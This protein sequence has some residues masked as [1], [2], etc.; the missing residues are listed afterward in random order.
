M[1]AEFRAA[2]LAGF[3]ISVHAIGDRA[4]R[5][6]LD[7]FEEL[8]DAGLQPPLPHRIEHVQILDPADWSRLAALGVTASVQP[9]HALDDMDT[10]ELFLGERTA[11]IYAFRSLL[12]SGALLAFGS[13]GPVADVN[14]FVGLHAAVVRQRPANLPAPAWHGEQRLTMAEAVYAYTLG[15]ARAVG[16]DNVIGSLTPG[17]LADLIVLD[18]DLFA[19]A[20]IDSPG[21][22]IADTQ[23]RMTVF[24]GEVVWEG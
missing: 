8:A 23:V 20:A 19:L 22:A 1:A 6:V 16:W 2:T 24:G 4:N 11:H 10:A 9:I 17:K 5:V 7:I 18:R 12:D 21:A 15:A 13:D 14:P 3:P